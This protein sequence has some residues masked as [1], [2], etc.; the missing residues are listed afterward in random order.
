MAKLC[1][2]TFFQGRYPNDQ[3]THEN[4]LDMISHQKNANY[5]TLTKMAKLQ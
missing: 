4:M 5:F 3:Q 2:Q 1:E